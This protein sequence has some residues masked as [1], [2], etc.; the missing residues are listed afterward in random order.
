MDGFALWSMGQK[1][2]KGFANE[3][4]L[5]IPS[6]KLSVEQRVVAPYLTQTDDNANK[7]TQK[8]MIACSHGDCNGAQIQ[9][10]SKTHNNTNEQTNELK[11]EDF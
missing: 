5:D 10:F 9:I 11:R 4:R 3:R 2:S 8:T 6:Q 7:Q 1:P